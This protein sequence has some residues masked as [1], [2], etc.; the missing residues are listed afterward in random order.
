MSAK[1]LI[2]YLTDHHASDDEMVTAQRVLTELYEM[3]V[4]CDCR[5]VQKAIEILSSYVHKKLN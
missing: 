5:E 2:K 3:K 4:D 1:G